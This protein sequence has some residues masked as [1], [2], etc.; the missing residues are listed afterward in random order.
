MFKD[1]CS[2]QHSIKVYTTP[3]RGEWIRGEDEEF[4]IVVTGNGRPQFK[5]RCRACGTTS[6][7]LPYGLI[8]SWGLKITDFVWT[9]INKPTEYEP[10]SV[11]GCQA[12]PTE[13][14]HFAPYNT[15][16]READDWPVMP[17]CQSHHTEWHQRMNGYQWNRK[18]AA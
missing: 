2:K 8:I 3:G 17:L 1:L 15:F 5:A 16:G 18:G 13:H 9:K 4:G 11:R 10:C 6:S 7:A 14:H 12:K